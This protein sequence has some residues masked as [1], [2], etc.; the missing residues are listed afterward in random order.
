MDRTAKDVVTVIVVEAGI[1]GE[2]VVGV[3]SEGLVWRG[4]TEVPRKETGAR[5]VLN[6]GEESSTKGSTEGKIKRRSE[7]VRDGLY[8]GNPGGGPTVVNGG[9]ELQ[10]T[11]GAPLTTGIGAIL[12]VP[13]TLRGVLSSD[14]RI[15]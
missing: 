2:G 11:A 15:P 14:S 7:D 3:T 5:G 6:T 9:W 4:A 13:G 12:E 8:L 1:H 10:G